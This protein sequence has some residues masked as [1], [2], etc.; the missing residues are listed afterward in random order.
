M[1]MD[2]SLEWTVEHR[3]REVRRWIELG[4]AHGE[5]V[6]HAEMPRPPRDLLPGADEPERDAGDR[7][8]LAVRHGFHVQIDAARE[9]E[10]ARDRRRDGSGEF[11]QGHGGM[12][13]T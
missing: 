12:L 6:A 7:L 8:L 5:R 9:I 3:V 1:M 10:D 2:H 11:D 4:D 13:R